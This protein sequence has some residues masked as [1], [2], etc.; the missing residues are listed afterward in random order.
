MVWVEEPFE[1]SRFK[2]FTFFTEGIFALSETFNPGRD[3]EL[4]KV[5][6]HLSTAYTGVNDFIVI[7]SHHLGSNFNEVLLSEPMFDTHDIL[8]QPRPTEKY[9]WNDT[10]N[11]TLPYHNTNVWGLEIG[12]WATTHGT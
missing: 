3:W 2:Y 7:M 4:D 12:F 9:H 10:L 5:R 1:V 11:I 8:F 6:L